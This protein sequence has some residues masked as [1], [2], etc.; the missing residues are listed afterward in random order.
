MKLLRRRKKE[1]KPVVIPVVLV[2]IGFG[3]GRYVVPID[4]PDYEMWRKAA[5]KGA[6]I[7]FACDPR[8]GQEHTRP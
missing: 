5:K 1:R 3:I 2:P 7:E 6:Q 8:Y 4:S